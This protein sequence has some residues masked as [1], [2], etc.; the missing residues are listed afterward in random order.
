M[1]IEELVELAGDGRERRLF[2]R[3]LDSLGDGALRLYQA[4]S[5]LPLPVVEQSLLDAID[6]VSE[7]DCPSEDLK[8]VRL[9]VEV[10]EDR[11]RLMTRPDGA[12]RGGLHDR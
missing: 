4:L 5:L 2:L 12:S 11:W 6:A 3:A 7:D 9:L 10:G 1:G 8:R